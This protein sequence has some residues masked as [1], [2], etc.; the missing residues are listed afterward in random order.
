MTGDFLLKRYVNVSILLQSLLKVGAL[1]LESAGV[2]L[3]KV[4]S[5]SLFDFLLIFFR[6]GIWIGLK[7]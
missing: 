7:R 2:L 4:A 6:L 3:D 5:L 1:L